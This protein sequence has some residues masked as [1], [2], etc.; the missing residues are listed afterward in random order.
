M[1]DGRRIWRRP[2]GPS[3][4]RD[5]DFDAIDPELTLEAWEPVFPARRGRTFLG[6]PKGAH[7]FHAFDGIAPAD[8]RC[9]IL[10][11][12][13]YPCAAF[14]TG[15][16]FEAGNVASLAGTREDVLG[17]RAHLHAADRRRANRR[18]VLRGS[19]EEWVR[20]RGEIESG[21]LDARAGGGD[22]RPLGPPGRPSPQL[23][24]D[25]QPLRRGGRS[26]PASRTPAALAA[27]HRFGPSASRRTWD[28]GGLCRTSATRPR[29]RFVA[30]GFRASS[31]GA[32]AGNDKVGLILREH[33]AKGD[34]VLAKENPV[35][36]VQSAARSKWAQSRC[37]GSAMAA[38]HLRL[39]RHRRRLRR[40]RPRQPALRRPQPFGAPARGR[41]ARPTSARSAADAH[42]QADAF[43]H[44][45][46]ALRDRARA[47][48]RQPPHLLAARQG[49]GR[50]LDDQ[51][52]DLCAR[53]RARLRPLGADGQ[54]LVL[55][56]RASLLPQVGSA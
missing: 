55:C 54:R 31:D 8:V 28:A 47:G 33:P 20:L 9:V 3:R 17:Q 7:I 29:M 56:R 36:A 18:S 34:R 2:G 50:H 24:A 16:A 23:V 39:H 44:L 21:R 25:H 45:Q 11:Q 4:P 26:A 1:P 38:R 41:R 49:A 13:P 35:R 19:T 6:A 37:R 5:L 48:A 12:D 14:S 10:G 52:H 27:V 51:R 46:L 15:R 30:P 53:Q 43:A 32:I 22:R 40:L 42:G